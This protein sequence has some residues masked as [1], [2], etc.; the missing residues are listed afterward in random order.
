MVLQNPCPPFYDVF[1]VKNS[2]AVH[3]LYSQIYGVRRYIQTKIHGQTTFDVI[4]CRYVLYATVCML[5]IVTTVQKR[6]CHSL[7]RICVP[8]ATGCI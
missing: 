3:G 5:Q 8:V 2:V 7:P 1:E 4:H 6:L